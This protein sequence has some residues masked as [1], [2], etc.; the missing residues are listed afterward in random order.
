MIQ[1]KIKLNLGGKE[2]TFH[3][4]LGF[5]GYLLDEENIGYVEFGEKEASN[6][7]KWTP[8]KMFY[9]LKYNYIRENKESEIDFDLKDVI[10]WIDE[11]DLNTLQSFNQA[12]LSSITKDVPTYPDNDKKKVVEK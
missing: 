11:T 6:P 8:I 7:F 10:E 4:G 12:Y 2:R 9:S 1:N 3:L 5:I